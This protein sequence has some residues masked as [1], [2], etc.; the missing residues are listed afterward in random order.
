[1]LMSNTNKPGDLKKPSRT[2]NLISFCTRGSRKMR[3]HT[4]GILD[5]DVRNKVIQQVKDNN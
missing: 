1:M 5:T 2:K 4:S 3:G